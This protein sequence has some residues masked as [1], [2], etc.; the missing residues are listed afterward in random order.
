[1][2]ASLDGAR[3]APLLIASVVFF[4]AWAFKQSVVGILS[5]VCLFE[6]VVHRSL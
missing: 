6:A 2:I 5:G 3:F 4:L 1:V